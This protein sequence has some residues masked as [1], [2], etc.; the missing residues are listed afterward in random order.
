MQKASLKFSGLK[1]GITVFVGI[2]VFFF[3][4][5]LI[6]NEGNYFDEMYKINTI[7]TNVDGLSE[8]AMVTLGGMKVGRVEK[9]K[10][11]FQEDKSA[12]EISMAIKKEY[13]LRITTQSMATIK[14]VGMLGDKFVDIS[15]GLPGQP[16]LKDGAFISVEQ[17]LSLASISDKL[18]PVLD[19]L[20]IVMSNLKTT[21]NNLKNNKSIMG[22]LLTNER[23]ASKLE[24]TICNL[25]TFSTKI[26]S[27]NSTIG[28]LAID[29][30]IYENIRKTSND[31]SNL[32]ASVKNGKGTLGKLVTE[33]SLYYSI[34]SITEKL[35]RLLNQAYS[36]T[37]VAGALLNDKQLLNKVNIVVAKLDT[38]I[39]DFK[40]HPERYIDLSIF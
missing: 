9:I 17:K 13:Q 27:R 30:E 16:F 39:T 1:T 29:T 26:N 14:T 15:I 10:F 18:V 19:D 38:L 5:I 12:I 35:D 32:T 23:L 6:G 31:L 7:V 21:T 24:Q 4:F 40:V 2:I 20:G 3:F 28:R 11:N 22:T 8:G 25:K 33:D 37:T 34:N 36:D